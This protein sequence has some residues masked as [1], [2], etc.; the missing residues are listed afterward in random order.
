MQRGTHPRTFY[1]LATAS[2]RLFVL[3]LY[4]P[5]ITIVVLS[6][7]GPQ[8][9]LT[10]PMNG[11]STALV[12]ASCSRAPAI[13]DIGG[14]FRRSLLLGAD[15]DGADRRAVGR[16]PASPSASAST[17]RASCSTSPSPA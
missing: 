1:V 8:G 17:A 15:R 2:S 6:F 11:V 9:G 10:F 3:F 16:W 12:R 4:G 14:G 5:T 13:V 7:Q